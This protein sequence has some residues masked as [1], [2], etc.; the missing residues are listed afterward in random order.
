M[1][2]LS[3]ALLVIAVAAAAAGLASP[4][5]AQREQVTLR[6]ERFYDHAC[7][8]YKFRFAGA[9]ASGAANE[10]VAVVQQTCGQTGSTAIAG[11][12]TREGGFWEVE[13]N[14][15]TAASATFRARW[16]NHLSDPVT[17]RG[18]VP[19][20]IAQLGGGRVRVDVTPFSSLPLR[21]KGRFVELQRL[22]AG[23]WTR[24]RRAR[25]VVRRGG[26]GFS[27]AFTVKRRGL[28]LRAFVPAQ[29]AAPCYAA[30]ASKTWTSGAASPA[31]SDRV[32][33]HTYLCSVA[34]QGGI[35]QLGVSASGLVPTDISPR[36][37]FGVSANWRDGALATASTE[38]LT[39]NPNRCSP[40]R[41]RIPLLP[42]GLEGG[43]VGQSRRSFECE[44]P[45]RVFVRLRAVFAAP[46]AFA[47][48]RTWGYRQL[49]ARGEVSEAAVAVRTRAGRPF[50]YA[51]LAAS[52][53]VRLFVAQ[54]CVDDS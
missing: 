16:N 15:P 27:A 38:S 4:A 9:I 25:F 2:R 46:T 28:T 12:S 6:V 7:R 31:G 43:S 41:T 3:V 14:G 29:S 21:L 8:C 50:A 5:D 37:S 45:S 40:S 26:A 22:S 1:R 33:D 47:D 30:T 42:R 20:W 23:Q 32:I 24:V 39:S 54:G 11:A 18:D 44:T 53:G 35:R 19:I 17:H 34:I 36:R 52:G 51:S 49:V 10:Y 48:D 13:S